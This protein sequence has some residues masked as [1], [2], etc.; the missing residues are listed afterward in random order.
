[1]RASEFTKAKTDRLNSDD[2]IGIDSIVV[3]IEKIEKVKDEQP[4]RMRLSGGEWKPWHP[5]KSMLRV[6][7]AAWGDEMRAWVGKSLELYREP[8]VRFGGLEVGG[9]RIRAMSGIDRPEDILITSTRGKKVPYP[10]RPLKSPQPAG[11]KTQEASSGG[12]DGPSAPA[13]R[14]S[15]EQ[16]ANIRALQDEIDPKI[17]KTEAAIAAAFNAERM[18]D[19]C[20]ENYGRIIHRLEQMRDGA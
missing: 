13:G 18:E 4:V 2:L 15:E 10:V 8:T 11:G 7:Q 19:I 9:T 3:T 14:L 17:R 1:M 20:A 16:L 12:G 6:M 5:C